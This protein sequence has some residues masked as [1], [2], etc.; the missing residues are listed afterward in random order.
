IA[1][2]R[3][4][5]TTTRT[6]AGLHDFLVPRRYGHGHYSTVDG[7]IHVLVVRRRQA[8]RSHR[9]R[10]HLPQSSFFAETLPTVIRGPSA[11]TDPGAI[12]ITGGPISCRLCGGRRRIHFE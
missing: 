7:V 2:W 12:V 1:R 9:E 3:E 8:S 6:S 4:C 10:H 5:R 11:H